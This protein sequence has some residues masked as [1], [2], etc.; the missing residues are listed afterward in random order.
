LNFLKFVRSFPAE[1]KQTKI[2]FIF[3]S[4]T[5]VRGSSLNQQPLTN[6]RQTS[7]PKTLDD[8]LYLSQNQP[9][10]IPR[11][12]HLDRL[13]N[14]KSPDPVVDTRKPSAIPN[15]Q[16]DF[17]IPTTNGKIKQTTS[18]VVVTPREKIDGSTKL[19]LEDVR[20]RKTDKIHFSYLC[21]FSIVRFC[22]TK[23]C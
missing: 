17:I 20:I 6:Q 3:Q 7:P 8:L 12:T 22:L 15:Y 18:P 4:Q 2:H 5:I 21:S 9:I 10:Q 11:N 16:N 23:S 14:V 13:Y 1:K 19:S